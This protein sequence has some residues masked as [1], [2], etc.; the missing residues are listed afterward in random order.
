MAKLTPHP[1]SQG[2]RFIALDL[3]FKYMK[4]KVENIGTD[5]KELREDF[6]TELKR[7]NE[8]LDGMNEKMEG[9]FANKRVEKAVSWLVVALC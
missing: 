5:V 7:L 8:K 4:E 6:G 9:K 2:E 1:C 3:Q